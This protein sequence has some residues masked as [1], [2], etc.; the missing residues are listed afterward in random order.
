MAMMYNTYNYWIL[1][2]CPMSCVLKTIEY[3][4]SETVFVSILRGGKET[5][6]V[7]D[8]SG[9]YKAVVLLTWVVQ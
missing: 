9:T 3:D 6:T 5:P 7:L 4:V 2:L 1:V 8:P